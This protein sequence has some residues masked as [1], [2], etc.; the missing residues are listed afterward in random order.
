MSKASLCVA[1]AMIFITGPALALDDKQ[2]L[3]ALNNVQS[4]M[5]ECVT[6]YASVKACIG[7]KDAKLASATQETM[8]AL[9]RMAIKVGHS[10]GMTEDAMMSRITMFK[11]QQTKLL[12]NNCANISSLFTRHAARCKKVVEN[13]DAILAE[14]LDIKKE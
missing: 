9:L 1:I 13:G 3:T 8:E 4:E 5:T 14:Y 2:V 12:Q 11:D 10:I 6:Y 7:S